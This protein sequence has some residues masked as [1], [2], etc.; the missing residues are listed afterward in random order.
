[1]SLS[2]VYPPGG[3]NKRRTQHLQQYSLSVTSG[4]AHSVSLEYLCEHNFHVHDGLAGTCDTTVQEGVGSIPLGNL[5]LFY[6]WYMNA[7]CYLFENRYSTGNL[8]RTKSSSL[9]ITRILYR[10]YNFNSNH[11]IICKIY[12]TNNTLY[13]INELE[14]VTTHAQLPP[15]WVGFTC[16]FFTARRQ[17]PRVPLYIISWFKVRKFRPFS[18]TTLQNLFILV[19]NCY[20]TLCF[21]W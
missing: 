19:P 21:S 3:C 7:F 10:S 17:A 8:F 16:F 6:T 4:T 11:S 14:R 12:H 13:Y 5:V 2:G 9:T 1:M 15:R 18:T 20:N